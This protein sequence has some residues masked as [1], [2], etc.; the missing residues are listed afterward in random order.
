MPAVFALEL[1][2]NYKANSILEAG[3]D[4]CDAMFFCVSPL[5]LSTQIVICRY[6]RILALCTWLPIIE[7]IMF[8]FFATL[9]L[10]CLSC[11]CVRVISGKQQC[12]LGLI[13]PT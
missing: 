2:R 3:M 4:K 9:P 13:S 10:R 1:Q 8:I 7:H 12:K 5:P 6:Y 11:M